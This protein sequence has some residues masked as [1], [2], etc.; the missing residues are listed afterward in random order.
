MKLKIE[1]NDISQFV[2]VIKMITELNPFLKLRIFK[3]GLRGKMRDKESLIVY[4]MFLKE[5]YFDTYLLSDEVKDKE[6]KSKSKSKTKKKEKDKED[7]ID[8][9]L[10]N[11]G[12]STSSL[13]E[14]LSFVKNNKKSD[15]KIE[16]DSLDNFFMIT[17]S[18][19][20]IERMV[21]RINLIDESKFDIVIPDNI[22]FNYRLKVNSDKWSSLIKKFR[23]IYD[24]LLVFKINNTKLY[25]ALE[26]GESCKVKSLECSFIEVNE[27]S[28]KDLDESSS[29][30]DG[31]EFSK[32]D[33]YNIKKSK[34]KDDYKE[35]Y[36]LDYLDKINKGQKLCENY[37]FY[38]NKSLGLLK[39][40]LNLNDD[41]YVR[42][43]MPGKVES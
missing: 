41:S 5:D 7:S 35:E 13:L 32:E 38:V 4:D 20:D 29:D 28:I 9:E 31:D 40:E 8:K 22:N 14:V 30:S 21:F 34:K 26:E 42:Y 37:Y 18:D 23:K 16:I 33:K 12:F 2:Q 36:N 6:K 24:G 25:L 19:D 3:D 17:L 39:I 27:L 11:M 43:Y 1:L 15:M 10:F